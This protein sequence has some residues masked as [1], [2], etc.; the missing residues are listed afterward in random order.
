MTRWFYAV[1]TEENATWSTAVRAR[2]VQSA[3]RQLSRRYP[4][5]TVFEIRAD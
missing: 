3:R 2:D 4:H 5:A 1:M